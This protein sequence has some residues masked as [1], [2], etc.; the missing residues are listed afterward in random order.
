MQ[1]S[2]SK[3]LKDNSGFLPLHDKSNPEDI[4]DQ[5][6]M[7][8]KAFKKAIGSLYKDRMITID[9]KRNKV[10]LIYRLI[11]FQFDVV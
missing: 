5:L 7:S 9:E 1:N 3:K 8:K 11:Q 2:F 10:S 4:K 6:Q